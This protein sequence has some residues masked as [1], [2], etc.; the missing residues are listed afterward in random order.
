MAVRFIQDLKAAG[1]RLT[2]INPGCWA[3]LR[4]AEGAPIDRKRWTPDRPVIEYEA[5]KGFK[6]GKVDLVDDDER[7]LM[8]VTPACDADYI[9]EGSFL[10]LTLTV[11]DIS[12]LIRRD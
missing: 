11:D 9:P 7:F 3:I 1:S 2:E 8:S 10:R 4:D 5:S 12:A 6:I